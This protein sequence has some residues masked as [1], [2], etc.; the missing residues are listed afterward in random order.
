VLVLFYREGVGQ[1]WTLSRQFA[2]CGEWGKFAVSVR[3]SKAER[4]SSSGGG[5]VPPI[6][7][8][9]LDLQTSEE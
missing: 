5:F 3:H 7:S 1:V 4:F 8:L 6:P 2:K 9:S